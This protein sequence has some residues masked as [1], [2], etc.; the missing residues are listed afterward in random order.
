MKAE[1]K[2]PEGVSVAWVACGGSVDGIDLE[3]QISS[4]RTMARFFGQVNGM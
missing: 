4:Q 3:G 1:L 2:K